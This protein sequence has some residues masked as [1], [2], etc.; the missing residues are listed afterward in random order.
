MPPPALDQIRGK[1]GEEVDPHSLL[2]LS[3]QRGGENAPASYCTRCRGQ[4]A[5]RYSPRRLFEEDR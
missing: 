1:K 2:D 4:R 3:G 5:K